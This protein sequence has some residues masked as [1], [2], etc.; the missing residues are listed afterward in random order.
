MPIILMIACI[1]CGAEDQGVTGALPGS[2]APTVYPEKSVVHWAPFDDWTEETIVQ[3]A[4]SKAM[5]V[6]MDRCFAEESRAV[7]E[8]L[9]ELNPELQILGYLP[10]LVSYELPRDTIGLREVLPFLFDYYETVEDD[11]AH[12]TTGDTL[13][14]WP[15]GIF[16]DPI[17]DDG[18]NRSLITKIVD[19]VEAYLTAGG[20][21]VDGI[22]H[23]Y[24]MY[25]VYVNPACR[26]G[27]EG[28]PDLDE[29]LI[30]C[31][32]DPDERELLLLW[33]KEY[34]RALRE[35]FGDDFIMVGN[36][37]PP[38]EDAELAGLLNGIFYES[39][40]NLPWHFTDREGFLRLV[41]NQ[42]EGFLATA[43]GRTW[44]ILANHQ[45]EQNNYFCLV[46]SLLAGC[47][48]TELHGSYLFTGWTLNVETGRPA[49]GISL[50]EDVDGVLTASR[51]FGN[52]EA[53][54]SFNPNGGRNEVVFETNR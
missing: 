12:T 51:P 40:P 15:G 43:K 34:L 31:G 32:E 30:P 6:P 36:G 49:G 3:A 50:E 28:E 29:D 14:I 47:L 53:R 52:G 39:F 26:P 46:S 9:R 13:M 25:S 42:S 5:V 20:P 45:L 19:L 2:A 23:D 48:Y 7:I 54:I 1:S 8:R 11:W 21:P 38:Q 16:L 22:M 33:Q 41:D 18:I 4:R 44:S 17:A 37:R 27:V 10:V 35:R 24:F